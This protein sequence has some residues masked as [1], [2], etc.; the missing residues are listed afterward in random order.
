M[1]DA[2]QG[3]PAR[4]RPTIATRVSS[5]KGEMEILRPTGNAPGPN[6]AGLRPG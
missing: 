4:L 1:R 6:P 3:H 2:V 5:G